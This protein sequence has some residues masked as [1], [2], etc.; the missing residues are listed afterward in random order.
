MHDESFRPG[1]AFK[2]TAWAG[3]LMLGAIVAGVLFCLGWA[4][5]AVLLR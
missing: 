4:M 3:A 2:A 5:A 1:T